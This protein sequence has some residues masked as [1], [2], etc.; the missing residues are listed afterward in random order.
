MYNLTCVCV[1][2]THIKR[3]HAHVIII[4]EHDDVVCGTER[5]LP[6]NFTSGQ[7]YFPI[8]RHSFTVYNHR[9]Y[10]AMSLY[11]IIRSDFWRN[12]KRKTQNGIRAKYDAKN[13]GRLS[14]RFPP[15]TAL[16][17]TWYAFEHHV[18]HVVSIKYGYATSVSI[19]T[20]C[21]VYP[22]KTPHIPQ[23][24]PVDL[25]GETWRSPLPWSFFFF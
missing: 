3:M 15:R 14:V 5:F 19:N 24:L 21:V 22:K 16:F 2:R 17:H 20:R 11:Y 18:I 25:R 9:R 23:R 12:A 6:L 7:R 10:C 4:Y 1:C 8:K 13:A